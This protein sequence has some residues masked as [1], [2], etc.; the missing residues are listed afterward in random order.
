M[1][2]PVDEILADAKS[3]DIHT[4]RHYFHTRPVVLLFYI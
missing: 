2:Y 3:I 4:Y 1:A